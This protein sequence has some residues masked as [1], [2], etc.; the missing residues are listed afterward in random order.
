[1]VN[2]ELR[3]IVSR[4]VEG[5]ESEQDIAA[6]IQRYNATKTATPEQPEAAEPSGLQRLAQGFI[7][8]VPN[9]VGIWRGL[10]KATQPEAMPTAGALAGGVLGGIVGNVPGAIAGAGIGGSLGKGGEI[11]SREARGEDVPGNALMSMAKRGAGEAA[12]QAAGGV[13]GKALQGIGR[14]AYRFALRPQNAVLKKYGDDVIQEGLDQGIVVRKGQKK[15][16]ELAARRKL[17]KDIAVDK[18]SE[19]ASVSMPRVM[20]DTAQGLWDES[21]AMKRAGLG[22]PMP[23]FERQAAEMVSANPRGITPAALEELKRTRDSRLGGA[24]RKIRAREPVTPEEQFGVQFVR[25]AGDTLEGVVPGYRD[26]NR[27]IMTATGLDRAIQTRTGT[28]AANNGLE[29]LAAMFMGPA[30]IPARIASM[31]P[32]ASSIGIAANQ[33]G[34]A[35]KYGLP[36]SVRAALLAMMDDEQK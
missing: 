20:D 22:D 33:A 12:L 4:M 11:M 16:A 14:G 29:N 34:K 7:D 17:E 24:F 9:P 2:D 27:G 8:Y 13:A 1:M 32:A 26:M 30:A 23:D 25:T 5:G 15:A 18:A 36:A 31:P 19:R 10:R 3:G 28:S 35:T 6:V 21:Q